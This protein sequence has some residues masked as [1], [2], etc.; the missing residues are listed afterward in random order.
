MVDV[1]AGTQ[2]P[3]DAATIADMAAKNNLTARGQDIAEAD[4]NA[5]RQQAERQAEM[6]Y[7]ADVARIN[8]TYWQEAQSLGVQQAQFNYQQRLSSA[9]QGLAA[10]SEGSRQ[11]QAAATTKLQALQ[12][13]ADRSGPQNWVR[14]NNLLNGLVGPVGTSTTIDPT[15]FA[16]DIVDPQFRAGAPSPDVSALDAAIN[17][18]YT[19]TTVTAPQLTVPTVTTAAPAPVPTSPWSYTAPPSPPAPATAP[20][21]SS[22]T[23]STPTTPAPS[24]VNPNN[25]G[26][27]TESNPHIVQNTSAPMAGAYSGVPNSQVAGLQKGQWQ[28][29]TTGTAGPSQVGDYQGFGVYD[30]SRNQMAD[31]NETIAGSTP[32]WLQKL[33]AGTKHGM[34]RDLMAIVGEGKGQKPGNTPAQRTLGNTGE[35]VVNPT[36]API[37]V[38]NNDQA[39]TML[40]NAHATGTGMRLPGYRAGSGLQFGHVSRTRATGGMRAVGVGSGIGPAKVAR[41]QPEL[42]TPGRARRPERT[43]GRSAAAA[44][45]ATTAG[46]ARERHAVAW[47]GGHAD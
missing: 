43:A 4:A 6:T 18:P 3:I 19:G 44:S 41:R 35:V 22:T 12:Q 29:V 15:A 37:G 38:L 2:I 32:L 28:L 10:V 42:I 30:S 17:Q 7:A 27:G 34:I 25:S 47:Y 45:P 23:N 13:L 11:R 24:Q 16:D 20:A 14:Y 5:A 9:Q 40:R 31:P 21:P 26:T 8:E 1:L 33:S 39:K 46:P 36:G